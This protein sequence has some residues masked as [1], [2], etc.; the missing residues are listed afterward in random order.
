MVSITSTKIAAGTAAIALVV[1]GLYE[2]DRS[3][4]M[5]FVEGHVTP[6]QASPGQL[7]NVTLTLDWMRLCE[8]D[9]SRVMRDGA[10]EEHKLP[11]SK[12]SPPP[13][14]GRLTSTR[15]IVVP[16]TAKFGKSACYR[17]TIYMQCGIIDRAFPIRVEMPCE[18][19]PLEIV[20]P[21][22]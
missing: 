14:L 3:A 8:L 15:Q 21:A 6:Q 12:S 1:F 17:A 22:K 13:K 9:V 19:M 20:P 7:V 18:A 10:G 4:P 16:A 2:I 5:K 11:W